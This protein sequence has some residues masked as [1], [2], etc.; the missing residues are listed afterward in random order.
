MKTWLLFVF[1][2]ASLCLAAQDSLVEAQFFSRLKIADK[3][4]QKELRRLK[5]IPAHSFTKNEYEGHDSLSL[6][7]PERATVNAFFI[8]PYEVSNGEYKEFV[9]YVRDSI[10]HLL[11]GH[12]RMEQDGSDRIDWKKPIDWKDNSMYEKINSMMESP[13]NRMNG[14]PVIDTEKIRYRI[15]TDADTTTIAVYPDTLC[16]LRDFAYAYGEP[17]IRRYFSHPAFKDYPVVGISYHQAL[18]FCVWKTRQLKNSLPPDFAYEITYTLPTATEWEAAAS[19]KEV[20]IQENEWAYKKPTGKKQAIEVTYGRDKPLAFDKNGQLTI[21]CNFFI[22]KD[23][24]GYVIKEPADDGAFY[25]ARID[26]YKPNAFGLYNM[27]GNVA[28]WTTDD[29]GSI[30]DPAIAAAK[31]SEKYRS[32]ALKELFAYNPGA[33]YATMPLDSFALYIR[34]YKIVKGGSWADGV[35]Y[36]QKGACQF[37]EPH[38]SSSFTG[39]RY[40][41]RV[42]RKGS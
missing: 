21:D 25:T 19:N 20:P 13:D 11:M 41:V 15:G 2:G 3:D 16:W 7:F 10:V 1:M 29:A 36:L 9:H 4:L 37:F 6:Y 14:I 40:V 27:R 31:E 34:K 18:A 5:W 42:R 30:I 23:E 38:T 24:N 35:F 33:L 17:L 28:E 8:A 32:G 26:A 39:F 12:T 22:L